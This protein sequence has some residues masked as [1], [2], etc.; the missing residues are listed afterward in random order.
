MKLLLVQ[1][2]FLISLNSYC[3]GGQIVGHITKN[4]VVLEYNYSTVV[5]TQGDSTITGTVPDSTGLFKLNNINEGVYDLEIRQIGYRD[6]V[7]Y[8]LRISNDTIT[9]I[10]IAY[11]PPCVFIYAKG[12][13]PICI[14]GHTDKIIPIVYGL[15]TKKTMKKAEKG[16]IH[17][18]GCIVTNCDPHYYC[19]IHKVEL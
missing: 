8:R 18:G 9:N 4:D 16:L 3:Q 14:G 5:L 7:S 19:T 15:P 10:A 2:L 12:Q 17:L 11:P 13:R 6:F 1:A